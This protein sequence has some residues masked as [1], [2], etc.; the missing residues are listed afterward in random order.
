MIEDLLLHLWKAVRTAT[1]KS[2]PTMVPVTISKAKSQ[3]GFDASWCCLATSSEGWCLGLNAWWVLADGAPPTK[4]T[5]SLST[6]MVG[7]TTTEHHCYCHARFAFDI[8]S[9]TSN[10]SKL[11]IILTMTQLMGVVRPQAIC[12]YLSKLPLINT[13]QIRSSFFRSMRPLRER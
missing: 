4:Q 9:Y 2:N 10:Y 6:I 3:A 5:S 12:I 11:R 1:R 13:D 8:R 7:N